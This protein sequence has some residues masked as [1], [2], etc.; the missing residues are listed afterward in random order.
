MKFTDL[1]QA[2][3]HFKDTLK[4]SKLTCEVTGINRDLSINIW[5][6]LYEINV[7]VDGKDQYLNEVDA[8]S[9]MDVCICMSPER[10]SPSFKHKF[11]LKFEN[12]EYECIECISV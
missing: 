1:H 4:T 7:V 5:P 3:K 12:N 6:I 11:L 8:D 10:C 9:L 2:I